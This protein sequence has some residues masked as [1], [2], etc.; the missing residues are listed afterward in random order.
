MNIVIFG[1]FRTI[2]KKRKKEIGGNVE[3]LYF[4]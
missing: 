3:M 4:Y 2:L 1:D